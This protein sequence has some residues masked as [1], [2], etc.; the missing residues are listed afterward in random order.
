VLYVGKWNLVWSCSV[1]KGPRDHL[2]R[3]WLLCGGF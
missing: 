1:I 3:E 2:E